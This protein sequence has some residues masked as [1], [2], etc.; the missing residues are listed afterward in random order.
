MP[1]DVTIE[2]R[3]IKICLLH[4]L[5]GAIDS[6]LILIKEN[7]PVSWEYIQELVDKCKAINHS[8]AQVRKHRAE[9]EGA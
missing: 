6:Q 4:E 2:L 8:I 1:G 9:S 7:R 3:D 5:L